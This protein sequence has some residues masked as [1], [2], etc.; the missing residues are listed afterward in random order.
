MKFD[1]ARGRVSGPACECQHGW[2]RSDHVSNLIEDDWCYAGQIA[3]TSTGND[4]TRRALLR[5]GR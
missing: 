4:V 5:N 2:M 3:D 1:P